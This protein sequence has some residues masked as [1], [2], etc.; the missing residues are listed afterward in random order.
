MGPRWTGIG[1]Y[2]RKLIEELQKL[3]HS[4]DYLVLVDQEQ[5]TNWQ[6]SAPNFQKI[7]AKQKVY[8][9][10]EQ[11]SLGRQIRRLNPDLV[12]FLHFN[13]PYSYSGRRIVTIH[14]TTLIDYNVS[15]GGIASNI[16]YGLKRFGM[17]AVFKQAL[18]ADRIIVPSL[19]TASNLIKRNV[20]RAKIVVTPEAADRPPQ[21]PRPIPIEPPI[22]LYVGN[23]YPY[24]NVSLLLEALPNIPQARLILVGNTPRFIDTL[25]AQA[26]RLGVKDRIE[27]S[28][29][30]D[31]Q[32]LNLTY[33][34]ASLFVFPSLSEGFGL[35]PLEAMARGV[36]VLAAKASC[37]PEVLGTAAEYFDPNDSTQLAELA[38]TVLT[39]PQKLK[40]MQQRGFDQVKKYS[41]TK[42]AQETL[43]IYNQFS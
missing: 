14:D 40:A 2:S 13:A 15:S 42:M 23:F 19:A 31:S 24:K 20:A 6:P 39:D 10:S 27:F 34:R 12:H 11:L 30:L 29:F 36:P 18:R 32:A 9:L 1:L 5:F 41:W 17:K 37:L 16:K 4:N 25:K 33:Q 26:T 21:S 28:G 7:L 8:S 22:L 38:A 43:S 35:P 3:D